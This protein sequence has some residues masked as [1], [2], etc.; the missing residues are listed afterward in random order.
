[1]ALARIF[2]WGRE[3]HLGVR[4]RDRLLADADLDQFWIFVRPVPWVPRSHV[5]PSIPDDR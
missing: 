5:C 2:G 3:R 4:L 1:M